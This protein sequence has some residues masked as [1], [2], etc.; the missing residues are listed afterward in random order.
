MEPFIGMLGP[1]DPEEVEKWIRLPATP[2][3]NLSPGKNEHRSV[4]VNVVMA[5]LSQPSFLSVWNKKEEML[6]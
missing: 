1:S 2:R 6:R 3:T 4:L 5:K